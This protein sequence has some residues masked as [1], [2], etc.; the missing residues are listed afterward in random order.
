MKSNFI[1]IIFSIFYM[2]MLGIAIVT[3]DTFFLGL[4]I[5]TWLISNQDPK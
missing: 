2:I 3:H 5:L 1:F 4:A